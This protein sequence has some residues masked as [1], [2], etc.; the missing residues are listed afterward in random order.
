M[1]IA[2]IYGGESAE[3]DVSIVTAVQLI[4]NITKDK[5]N[6]IPIYISKTGKMFEV[7][8]YKNI[9][10]Y[11]TQSFNREVCFMPNSMYLYKKNICGVYSK[12]KK[13][14]FCY[15]AMHGKGGEDGTMSAVLNMSHIPYSSSGLMGSSVCLDKATFK[16]AMFGLGVNI[17]P[18]IT[19]LKEEYGAV[20]E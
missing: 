1:N 18:F 20:K 5:N 12:Y 4:K 2:V 6:I 15:I 3:H 10:L 19:V 14:D 13:V 8:D 7:K 9:H 16:N 11:K 17:F